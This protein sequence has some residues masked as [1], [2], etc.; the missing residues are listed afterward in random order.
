MPSSLSSR[1]G[2]SGIAIRVTPIRLTG[3]TIIYLA[4]QNGWRGAA[5]RAAK[6]PNPNGNDKAAADQ[7]GDGGGRGPKQADMLIALADEA[8]LFHTPD[9]T[10]FADLDVNG[11]RETWPIRRKDFRRWLVRRFFKETGGAPNSEALQ[12]ALDLI[13]AKAQFDGPECEVFIRVGEHGGKLYL[14]LCD[15]KWRAVEID[16]DGWRIVEEPPLRFRRAAGMKPLPEPLRGGSIAKLRYFLNVASKNDFVLVVAWVLAGLRDRG[17]YPVLALAGEQG[18]GK[19][20]FVAILRSLVDPNVAPLRSLPREERDLFIAA[21]NGHVL[22][23][24]NV[25][26]LPAWL[27]DALCRVA[28]GAAFAVRQNYTDRTRCCSPPADRSS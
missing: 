26:G 27:S 9:G 10:G 28:T 5:Q 23:F 24:D 6:P 1:N 14:D 8:K 17:P 2:E 12:S 25:S 18:T 7:P 19:S 4:R 11:H 21:T 22:A 3:G 13:E 15:D 16:A 20:L